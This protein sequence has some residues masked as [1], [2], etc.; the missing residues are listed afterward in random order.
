[1]RAPA[2]QSFLA[3]LQRLRSIIYVNNDPEHGL[4]TPCSSSDII[5]RSVMF[6][7]GE[8]LDEVI[9]EEEGSLGF[10]LEPLDHEHDIHCA[11]FYIKPHGQAARLGVEE[12]WLIH[13]ID[14]KNVI[15][16]HQDDIVEILMKSKRPLRITFL[17]PN[18]DLHPHNHHHHHHHREHTSIVTLDDDKKPWFKMNYVDKEFEESYMIVTDVEKKELQQNCGNLRVAYVL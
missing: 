18:H 8:Q 5:I 15:D 1:M 2:F 16:E 13:T 17:H 12:H 4:K 11:V 10:G 9:F 7:D 6:E 3:D 14:G